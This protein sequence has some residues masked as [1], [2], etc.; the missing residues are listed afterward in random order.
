[1]CL[2]T[3]RSHVPACMW[4]H[5]LRIGACT[6]HTACRRKLDLKN[7]SLPD[8]SFA[9]FLLSES[10]ASLRLLGLWPALLLRLHC[11]AVSQ[12]LFVCRDTGQRSTFGGV[13]PG[14]GGGSR[15]SAS[16]LSLRRNRDCK[17]RVQMWSIWTCPAATWRGCQ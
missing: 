14:G 8:T 10:P 12:C 15:A 11:C 2:V 3:K 6:S 9:H 5:S 7:N 13:T 16:K 4:Q 17:C 1:M